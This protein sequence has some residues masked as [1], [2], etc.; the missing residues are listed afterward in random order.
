MAENIARIIAYQRAEMEK[1]IAEINSI[2]EA[3][4]IQRMGLQQARE[5]AADKIRQM[6]KSLQ[7][8]SSQQ[9]KYEVSLVYARDGLRLRAYQ[10]TE[11]AARVAAETL[12]QLANTQA[13]VVEQMCGSCKNPGAGITLPGGG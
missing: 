6:D 5:R 3:M 8:R 2:S 13:K 9:Y 10:K 4:R 7:Y 12:L 1:T 11:Q